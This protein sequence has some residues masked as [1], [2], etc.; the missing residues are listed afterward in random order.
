AMLGGGGGFA[1]GGFAVGGGLD[2]DSESSVQVS[3][4][5]FRDDEALGGNGGAGSSTHLAGGTGGFAEGGGVNVDFGSTATI[6]NVSFLDDRA[7]GGAGGAGTTSGAA[8]GARGPCQGRP[9]SH[10]AATTHPSNCRFRP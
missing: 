3:N 8:G 6:S 10:S 2:I 4:S 9:R 1:E 5:T 7:Q